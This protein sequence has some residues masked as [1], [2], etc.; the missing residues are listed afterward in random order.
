MEVGRLFTSTYDGGG[1]IYDHGVIGV[2]VDILSRLAFVSLMAV[3]NRFQRIRSYLRTPSPPSS[4]ERSLTSAWKKPDLPWPAISTV[5]SG[6][7]MALPNPL[8]LTILSA[9][10][11]AGVGPLFNSFSA[12]A[13]ISSTSE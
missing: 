1:A 3:P 11:A 6:V 7:L 10:Y 4:S 5:A 2:F 9:L 12:S 8:L 13:N